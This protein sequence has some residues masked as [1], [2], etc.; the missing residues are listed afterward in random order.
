MVACHTIWCLEQPHSSDQVLPRHPRF[1]WL[2]NH[3][4]YVIQLKIAYAVYIYIS[5]VHIIFYI[6]LYLQGLEISMLV[7]PLWPEMPQAFNVLGK[8]P[9]VAS[10]Y[11]GEL[12]GTLV[13]LKLFF[14]HVLMHLIFLRTRGHLHVIKRKHLIFK[15]PARA[16][17][18]YTCIYIYVF[19][20]VY[21]YICTYV[22]KDSLRPIWRL[23]RRQE[24]CGIEG[25]PQEEWVGT[26]IVYI[27]YLT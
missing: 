10:Q 21:P 5:Y 8:L 23:Q 7:S 15:L 16:L 25:Q 13:D 14:N 27:S 1:E 3:V 20:S 24:V 26:S 11:G 9:R 2:C 22:S 4:L 18:S 17:F 19:G 12:C 6:Y